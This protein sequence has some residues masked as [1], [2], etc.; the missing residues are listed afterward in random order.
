VVDSLSISLSGLRAESKRVSVAASNIANVRTSGTIPTNTPNAEPSTVYRA[1]ELQQS[2]VI[3]GGTGSGVQTTVSERSD[4]I[5]VVFDP[6]SIFADEDGLIAIPNI[7]LSKEI[8]DLLTAK[9]AYKA[10]V[11]ALK[12]ADEVSDALLDTLA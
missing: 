7:D 1:Q 10:N 8:V 2:S 4:G 12:V 11:F 9:T 5:S 3:T 6:S